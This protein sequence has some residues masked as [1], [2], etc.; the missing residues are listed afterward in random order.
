M[1]KVTPLNDKIVVKRAE[2]ETQT[3]S[4]IYLPDSAAEKPQQAK[5]I[6][7][8]QGSLNEKTGKRVVSQVKK[9]DTVLLSKWGG[10]EINIDDKELLIVNEDD[11]L[12][13]VG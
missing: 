4:G 3:A 6:A 13:I 9:G 5:V 10:T 1:S 2:A 8:G 7:V 11:I 12:A